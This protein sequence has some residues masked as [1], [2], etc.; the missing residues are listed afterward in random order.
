MR[1]ITSLWVV[2]GLF[3]TLLRVHLHFGL[4][5]YDQR[6]LFESWMFAIE[7]AVIRSS[8]LFNRLHC[9]LEASITAKLSG[10]TYPNSAPSWEGTMGI[11]LTPTKLTPLPLHSPSFLIPLI[12]PRKSTRTFCIPRSYSIPNDHKAAKF[13]RQRRPTENCLP[14]SLILTIHSEL[15][16]HLHR[17]SPLWCNRTHPCLIHPLLPTYAT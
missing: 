5:D 10:L 6:L 2:L 11:H 12:D 1:F 17:K 8:H 14:L 13:C 15:R 7:V 9:H 3:L 16:L 4:H